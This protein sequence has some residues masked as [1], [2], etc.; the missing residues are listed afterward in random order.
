MSLPSEQSLFVFDNRSHTKQL[1]GRLVSKKRE[2]FFEYD[3]AFLKVGHELSPFKLPLKAGV[4][5]NL[6]SDQ[7]C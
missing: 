2:I 4:I 3:A 5:R 1:M 7:I 6:H